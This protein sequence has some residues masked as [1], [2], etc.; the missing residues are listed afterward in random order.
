[1]NSNYFWRLFFVLIGFPGETVEPPAGAITVDAKGRVVTPGLVDM[2]SHIGVYALPEMVI[3]FS[4][5]FFANFL[6]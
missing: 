6:Y 2:H 4:V 3:T 1:M 5:L